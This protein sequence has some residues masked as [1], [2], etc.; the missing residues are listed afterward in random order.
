MSSR[1]RRVSP[2]KEC[3]V[4]LRFRILTNGNDPHTE[5]IVA[6]HETSAPRAQAYSATFEGQ[7]LNLSECG[8]YF[9]SREKLSV[10]EPLEIYLTLP[11]ELTGRSPEPVRCS[12]R[13]VHVEDRHDQRGMKGIGAVVDRFEAVVARRSWSN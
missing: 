1:E 2:R 7:A 3:A 9:T 11:R 10:G 4:P 6:S 5:D 13:V 12:A 8:L